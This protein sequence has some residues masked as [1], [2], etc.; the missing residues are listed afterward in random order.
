MM[1]STMRM[2]MQDATLSQAVLREVGSSYSVY[3]SGSDC[4]SLGRT[5]RW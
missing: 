5:L 3:S 1:L 4:Q 2:P